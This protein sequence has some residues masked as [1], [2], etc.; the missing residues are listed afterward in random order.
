MPLR[1][2]LMS[3]GIAL[4]QNELMD[5][6]ASA[7]SLMKGNCVQRVWQDPGGLPATLHLSLIA[8]RNM[9]LRS[10]EAESVQV[11]NPWS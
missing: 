2:V 3:P 8:D 4:I 10:D 5:F 7:S 11:Q 1:V 9:I 6:V